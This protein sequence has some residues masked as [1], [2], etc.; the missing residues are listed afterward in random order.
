ML[1]TVEQMDTSVV[2]KK[3]NLYEPN[4]SK[5]AVLRLTGWCYKLLL[6]ANESY[7][8][9]AVFFSND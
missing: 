1:I 7:D 9:H 5:A 4:F 3:K 6:Y 8:D 2:G